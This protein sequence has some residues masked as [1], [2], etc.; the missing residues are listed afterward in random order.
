VAARVGGSVW[1]PPALGFEHALLVAGLVRVA[2]GE[3][4]TRLADGLHLHGV[5]CPVAF[6]LGH[7]QPA[8]LR[9]P[10]IRF[11]LWTA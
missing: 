11:I 10:G 3:A 6:E 9:P 8:I 7:Y 5:G 1:E 2:P 4:G